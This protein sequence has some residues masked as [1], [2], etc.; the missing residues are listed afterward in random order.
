MMSR[1][2]LTQ[3]GKVRMKRFVSRR[4]KKAQTGARIQGTPVGTFLP[5][6]FASGELLKF[7]FVFSAKF[8]ETCSADVTL[9]LLSH[10]P[11]PSLEP[12]RLIPKSSSQ[13]QGT[14]TTLLLS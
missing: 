2:I 5:F 9:D 13:R 1:I 11:S 10:Q 8:G 7:Y 3:D 6:V 12:P 4:K 14:S